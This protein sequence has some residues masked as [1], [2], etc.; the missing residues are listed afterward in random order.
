MTKYGDGL[1]QRS[2][3]VLFGEYLKV[4]SLTATFADDVERTLGG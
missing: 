2:G 3:G 4:A 1:W